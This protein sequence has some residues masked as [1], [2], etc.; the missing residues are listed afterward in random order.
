MWRSKQLDY[1]SH[2]RGLYLFTQLHVHTE[3]K[4]PTEEQV[5]K[6][7]PHCEGESTR[8]R[9]NCH[10]NTDNCGI[11]PGISDRKGLTYSRTNECTSNRDTASKFVTICISSSWFLSL[12]SLNG[13]G[14]TDFFS[15]WQRAQACLK[16]RE[17]SH[18]VISAY[19]PS[20]ENYA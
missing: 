17:R 19:K 1:N 20:E 4:L 13:L 11:Q 6:T 15:A 18:K 14:H 8:L 12:K 7:C 10:L 9:R 16:E 5:A 3:N 2:P